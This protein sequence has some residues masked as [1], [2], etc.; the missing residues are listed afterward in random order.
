MTESPTVAAPA[1][2][3]EG[4]VFLLDLGEGENRVNPDFLAAV[5]A[6]LD[7][8]EAAPAPRAL[9][10]VA[11]GKYW[12]NGLDLEWLGQ[13]HERVQEVVDGLHALLARILGL[14]VPT[15]AAVQGHAFAGGALLAI[16]HDEL[17]MRADRGY[18][19]V[20]EVDLR[21]PFT[22]GMTAL[23][24]ARLSPRTAHE[25]MTTGRRYGGEQALAAGLATAVASEDEVVPQAV[26][27][28]AERA[29]KDPATLAT[30]KQ[31]L[32]RHALAELTKPQPLAG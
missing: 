31:R 30:I 3:R 21:L 22:D 10:T 24:A 12:S 1:L 23:L 26:A 11:R 17:V 4:D 14:G 16:A 32:Y 20:P 15:A 6:A 19:C 8:V 28:A 2:R 18:L 25:A 29:G 5:G 13:H 27:L 7:E 9:V